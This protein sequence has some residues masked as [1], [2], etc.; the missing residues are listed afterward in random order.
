[1]GFFLILYHIITLRKINGFTFQPG[2]CELLDLI[3]FIVKV[4][5]YGYLTSF[6]FMLSKNYISLKDSRI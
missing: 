4:D 3:R 6:D 1:M 2:K 5:R